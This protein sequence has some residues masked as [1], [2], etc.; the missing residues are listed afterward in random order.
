MTKTPI[1]VNRPGVY[2]TRSGRLV[3]ITELDPSVSLH[4]PWRG[5]SVVGNRAQAV[6][7]WGRWN[8]QGEPED[9]VEEN[10]LLNMV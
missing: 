5:Y 4:F 6:M 7:L 1:A 8:S 9:G 10:E 3:F 2:A